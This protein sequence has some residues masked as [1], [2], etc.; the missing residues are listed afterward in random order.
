[1][2]MKAGVEVRLL[3]VKEG[4]RYTRK[5]PEAGRET[6]DGSCLGFKN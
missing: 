1:M 5:P 4:Q 3:Q 6:W 2:K